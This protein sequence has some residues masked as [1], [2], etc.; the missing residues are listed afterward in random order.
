MPYISFPGD[1]Q[2]TM[3]EVQPGNLLTIDTG[4]PHLLLLL[5]GHTH[6]IALNIP[7]SQPILLLILGYRRHL[8]GMIME[9]L[10]IVKIGP[11]NP[12]EL[13]TTVPRARHQS[14]PPREVQ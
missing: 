8:I 6:N 2:I 13:N 10:L 11:H 4:T 14:L 5:N 9:Y 3:E 12:P 1:H 7:N